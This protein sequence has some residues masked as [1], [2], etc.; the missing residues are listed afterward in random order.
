[1]STA[2]VTGFILNIP[3]T[4]KVGVIPLPIKRKHWIAIRSVGGIFYNLDS[5]LNTPE[6]IGGETELKS[7]LK[8]QLDSG[9]SELFIIIENAV[10]KKDV[11]IQCQ[12]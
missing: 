12:T 9:Q 2:R 5:K 10:E 11:F 6:A 3:S 4:V 8:A 7:F 1:M